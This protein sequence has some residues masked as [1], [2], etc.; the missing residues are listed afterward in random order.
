MIYIYSTTVAVAF[1]QLRTGE[2]GRVLSGSTC[3]GDR[4]SV[5]TEV[6]RCAHGADD[7]GAWP[8]QPRA[9]REQVI[10]NREDLVMCYLLVETGFR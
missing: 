2:S 5:G 8:S 9:I 10:A 6:V 7:S 1:G 3:C 4:S